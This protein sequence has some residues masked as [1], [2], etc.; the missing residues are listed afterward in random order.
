M[1]FEYT[2]PI[3]QIEQLMGNDNSPIQSPQKPESKGRIPSQNRLITIP[4]QECLT[5][6][7]GPESY[8]NPEDFVGS[9]LSSI[10]SI[11]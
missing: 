9:S 4:S 1:Q 10:R 11:P 8:I 2:S 3:K 5:V 6:N 7:K